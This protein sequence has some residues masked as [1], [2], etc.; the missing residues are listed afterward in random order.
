MCLTGHKKLGN[1][2][3]YGMFF[4][5]KGPKNAHLESKLIDRNIAIIMNIMTEV[6]IRVA[7]IIPMFHK[8]RMRATITRS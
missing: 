7:M 6:I 4:P 5:K 3:C 8:Y 2:E 1:I